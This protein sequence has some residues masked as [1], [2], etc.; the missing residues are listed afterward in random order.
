VVVV[1]MVAGVEAVVEDAEEDV[2]G[3]VHFCNC[4]LSEVTVK[5]LF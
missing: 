3:N 2:A 4:L 1:A 5:V